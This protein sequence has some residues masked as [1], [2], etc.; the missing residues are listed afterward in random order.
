MVQLQLSLTA[1]KNNHQMTN[2]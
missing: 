2:L 1:N